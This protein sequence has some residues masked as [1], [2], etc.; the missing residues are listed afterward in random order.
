LIQPVLDRQLAGARTLTAALAGLD[1]ADV[2]A[3]GRALLDERPRTPIDLG[4]E[5]QERW[6]D[7]DATALAYVVR[8]LAP[9]VQIP[10]RGV[11]GASGRTTLATAETW[12]GQPLAAEPSLRAVIEHYL[13]AFG[14][15]T[16]GDIQAWSGLSGLRETVE[17][18]R[19]GLRVFRDERDR[20]LFD[21]PDA[22][23]P[24]PDLPAPPRFLPDFDNAL[25]G[26]ADRNRVFS[27]EHRRRVGIGRPTLLVDGV[28]Q[29]VWSLSQRKGA[30]RLRVEPFAPLAPHDRTAIEME[31]ERLLAFLAADAT[32]RDIDIV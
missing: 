9:L 24:D 8:N 19:P 26:H 12:L 23:L 5:L 29:G 30:A 25:L 28:V 32:D 31:G 2:V 14:P 11:W 15:A 16:V 7:R 22:P 3:A 6:P 21:V 20:E 4:K 18:M 17:G 27:D 1:A 13:A 10:P